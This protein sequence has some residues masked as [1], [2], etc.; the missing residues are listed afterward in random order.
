MSKP[1][2]ISESGV[3]E[4]KPM[5]ISES[6]VCASKPMEISESG[7]C[8][9]KRQPMGPSESGVC[10]SILWESHPLSAYSG[11]LNHEK[12]KRAAPPRCLQP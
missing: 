1:M 2:G 11:T 7:D 10:A 12:Y 8:E 5:G 6:G 4:S 3:C 9:S